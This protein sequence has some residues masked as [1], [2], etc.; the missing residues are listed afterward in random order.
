[1]YQMVSMPLPVAIVLWFSAGVLAALC[2]LAMAAADPDIT[3]PYLLAAV[4]F[5]AWPFLGLMFAYIVVV[6]V[7]EMYWF[8]WRQ[9][10]AS[11]R[12]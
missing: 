7:A 11:K 5:F 3:R 4:S 10:R 6:E 8:L 12:Q 1:M 2:A 9:H